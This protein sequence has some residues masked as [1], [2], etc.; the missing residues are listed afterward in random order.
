MIVCIALM[1]ADTAYFPF[2]LKHISYQTSRELKSL[3][4]LGGLL[5]IFCKDYWYF[6]LLLISTMLIIH[7]LYHRLDVHIYPVGIHYRIDILAAFSF[8]VL[9]AARGGSLAHEWRPIG[10][11]YGGFAVKSP[12]DLTLL[13]NTP[14]SILKTIHQKGIIEDHYFS[15]KSICSGIFSPIH[16]P[17]EN[18]EVIINKPNVIFLVVESLSDE[19]TESSGNSFTP[20]IDQLRKKSLK[21]VYSFANGKKSIEALPSIW[22]GIPSIDITYVL[23]PYVQNKTESIGKILK[24]EGYSTSFFHGAPKGSMGFDGLCGLASIDQYFGKDQYPNQ[25]DY[26]GIWGIWD[27]KFLDFTANQLNS[28]QKPFFSTIFTLS[29]H[30]P[31]K[32][33]KEFKGKFKK[34]SHPIFET[35]AY[36]D[37]ALESFFKKIEKSPWFKNTIFVI[38]G[39]HTSSH[40]DNK[41]FVTP[42]GR[43]RVPIFIY[44][45]SIDLSRYSPVNIQ[46]TDIK[47]SLVYLLGIKK[48]VFSFG[49]NIFDPT[50]IPFAIQKTGDTYQWVEKDYVLYFDGKKSSGLFNFVKDPELKHNT[51][52]ELKSKADSMELHCKAWL[53]QYHYRLIHNQLTT[54]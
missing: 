54:E 45:P 38:T 16:M 51:Y 6:I 37:F 9:W 32:V 20:F 44:S 47:P 12:T 41:V 33:P 1:L 4:N 11:N 31:F 29:S 52:S 27:H 13:V 36:T 25:A 8:V 19:A 34:G 39:D 28:L 49:K 48:D 26:D 14:F 35:L 2:I 24:Q 40:S 17:F 15:T 43:Y 53:Q 3:H 7:W 46:Q 50:A 21:S 5:L 22:M 23:S 42:L 18:K 10:L 30:H